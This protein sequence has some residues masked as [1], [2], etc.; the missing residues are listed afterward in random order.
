[1]LAFRIV[2]VWHSD[3]DR[4][5]ARLPRA[6]AELARLSAAPTVD[7]AIDRQTA[8]VV[9]IAPAAG[10]KAWSE[11]NPPPTEQCGN[12]ALNSSAVTDLSRRIHSPAVAPRLNV[13]A[14][15]V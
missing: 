9:S 15:I 10:T 1:M 13:N 2:S 11:L 14:A 12:C 7:I 3:P 4:S 8:R 6:V 5:Q